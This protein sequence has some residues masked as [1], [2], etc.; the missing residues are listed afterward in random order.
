MA[1]ALSLAVRRTTVAAL[2][3]AAVVACLA[4]GSAWAAGV[5]GMP[6]G[7]AAPAAI[8]A[9]DMSSR[10]D[11]VR[12]AIAAAVRARMGSDAV[13]VVSDLAVSNGATVSFLEAIPSPEA[14]LGGRM[15][16]RLVGSDG[17]GERT[18][19]VGTASARV[20]V[21]VEHVRARALLTR[22]TVVEDGAVETSHDPLVN[23][24][25]RRLPRMR[26]IA[27]SRILEHVA[28]GEVLTR[29]SVALR[30]AV[31][32]GQVVKAVAHVGLVEVAAA[33][34]AAQDGAPGAIIRV[35]NKDSRRELRARVVEPGIVEVLP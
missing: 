11:G 30:P 20:R 31:K 19:A 10:D 26:E 14:R 18:R 28:P 35:V 9:T 16:F 33:L 7:V 27:G 12:T 2:A 3:A 15:S 5:A 17:G 25:L 34:V 23:L 32:S 1:A 21:D 29:T 13:V 22:G 4:T 8:G 6:A 24:P